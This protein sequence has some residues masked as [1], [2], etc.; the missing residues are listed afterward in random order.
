[1]NN[2][3]EFK[4]KDTTW[5]ELEHSDKDERQRNYEAVVADCNRWDERDRTEAKEQ[6]TR[7]KW[8]EW[9][10]ESDRWERRSKRR[11]MWSNFKWWCWNKFEFP[12]MFATVVVIPALIIGI[13]FA[14]IVVL[15]IHLG[16]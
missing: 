15:M 4:I 10:K 11:T 2:I 16:G 12:M 14:I 5:I 3:N 8:K 6:E 9:K 1:M 13:P 7:R